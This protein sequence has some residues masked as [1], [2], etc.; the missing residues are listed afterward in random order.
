MI[1][2][3]KNQHKY[4]SAIYQMIHLGLHALKRHILENY[5]S[6][7]SLK[8]LQLPD[9]T[10]NAAIHFDICGVHIILHVVN[11]AYF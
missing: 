4:I 9:T 7:D 2:F 11:F 10:Y 1:S 6:L 5:W 8:N 3:C